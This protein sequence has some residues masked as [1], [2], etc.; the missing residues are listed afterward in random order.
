MPELAMGP[1]WATHCIFRIIVVLSS[2]ER[3]VGDSAAGTTPQLHGSHRDRP[4]LAE[5]TSSKNIGGLNDF[6]VEISA[7]AGSFMRETPPLVSPRRRPSAKR[8]LT[9]LRRPQA[10]ST[11]LPSC[12]WLARGHSPARRPT[13]DGLLRAAA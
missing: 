4:L 8:R 9:S 5:N 10:V 12:G 13:R 3:H 11:H 6:L 2:M 1:A 7:E